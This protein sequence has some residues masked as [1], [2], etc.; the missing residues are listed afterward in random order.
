[1]SLACSHDAEPSEL[2]LC[3]HLAALG[4]E[5]RYGGSWWRSRGVGLDHGLLC[6]DCVIG[7][8]HQ[9]GDVD[10]VAVLSVCLACVARLEEAIGELMIGHCGTLVVLER[11]GRFRSA[12]SQ[13]NLDLAG[14]RLEIAAPVP[15]MP[16]AATGATWV[17]LCDNGD[18]VAIDLDAGSVGDLG[19]VSETV[20]SIVGADVAEGHPRGGLRPGALEHLLGGKTH[21][22]MAVAPGGR[23]VALCA[24]RGR[25]GAVISA[26]TGRVVLALDRS[27][28]FPEQ[29]EFPLAWVR[30]TDGRPLLVHATQWN[31]L[32]LTDVSSGELLTAREDDTGLRGH[33]GWSSMVGWPCPTTSS[34]SR[35]TDGS[36]PR[37][38]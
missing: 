29:S 11:P 21:L 24:R 19:D 36:G 12:T 4:H 35:S 26:T 38:G 32:D 9:V 30:S 17:A 5:D 20:A 3:E 28:Y 15:E 1:M 7:E 8:D 37:S 18:L 23:W 2:G 10:G 27:G 14:R 22:V 13:V 6:D 31:R 25:A 16:G 34:T 33:W